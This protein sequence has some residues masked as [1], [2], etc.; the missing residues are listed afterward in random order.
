MTQEAYVP[1]YEPFQIDP[2]DQTSPGTP[3]GATG[4]PTTPSK[5]QTSPGTSAGATGTPTTPSKTS[6][7]PTYP[8]TSA[9]RLKTGS[10]PLTLNYATFKTQ[11][12]FYNLDI[13]SAASAT[14]QLVIEANSS[15]G[16]IP[17]TVNVTISA[18]IGKN[19]IPFKA[20]IVGV[21]WD[22]T[23][24]GYV[25]KMPALDGLARRL[26]FQVGNALGGFDGDHPVKNLKAT[27]SL[28]PNLPAGTNGFIGQKVD[29][30]GA[31]TIKMQ[32]VPGPSPFP[33]DI[34]AGGDPTFPAPGPGSLPP[35]SLPPRRGENAEPEMPEPAQ[36]A[37]PQAEDPA[38]PGA[39]PAPIPRPGGAVPRPGSSGPSQ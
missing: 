28:E 9:Y 19:K 34:P 11:N 37:R 7:A 23:N 6:P 22:A 29:V 8:P 10:T 30:I 5:N 32:Q 17:A 4:N 20:R 33:D 15:E 12:G 31:L 13:S 14:S 38:T 24:K 1:V 26:V 27:V 36:P 3:A 16:I 18:Q 39:A 2:P 25:I 21:P 35:G